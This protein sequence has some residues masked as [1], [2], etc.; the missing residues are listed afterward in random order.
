[1]LW[2]QDCCLASGDFFELA[3][4]TT[5]RGHPIK[6]RVTGAR[7]DT[8]RF[9]FSN[10]VIKAWNALPADIIMSPSV[11]TFKRKSP[12]LPKGTRD[13]LLKMPLP[14]QSGTFATVVSVCAPTMTSSNE[15]RNRFHKDLYTLLVNVQKADELNI[16]RK[17]NVH[18]RTEYAVWQGM[19]G[20]HGTE[21]YNTRSAPSVNLRRTS[22]PPDQRL[23]PPS[24]TG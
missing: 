12:G 19:L 17:F 22:F 15:M 9:F 4:T 23:L 10:R 2:L 13:C 3:T 21:D 8:R 20:L 7:L 6:L 1:M 16:R 11:D 18:I 24:D 5:L 14:L